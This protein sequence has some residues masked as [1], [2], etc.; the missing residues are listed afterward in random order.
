M[1][2]FKPTEVNEPIDFIAEQVNRGTNKEQ[3]KLEAVE[4]PGG[5]GLINE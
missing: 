2:N 1:L 4:L 3:I 5:F